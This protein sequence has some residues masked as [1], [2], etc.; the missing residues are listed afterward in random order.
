MNAQARHHFARLLIDRSGG[1]VARLRHLEEVVVG[2]GANQDSGPAQFVVVVPG[3]GQ[4]QVQADRV[5]RHSIHRGQHAGRPF[6]ALIGDGAVVEREVG[7]V[8]RIGLPL[9]PA[10][11]SVQNE[12]DR[13]RAQVGRGSQIDHR[14]I[15]VLHAPLI[16]VDGRVQL[17][18]ALNGAE[19]VFAGHG[20]RRLAVVAAIEV[21]VRIGMRLE[22]RQVDQVSRVENLFG[23]EFGVIVNSLRVTHPL[24]PLRPF[25]AAVIAVDRMLGLVRFGRLLLQEAHVF[26]LAPHLRQR[27][28]HHV[29]LGVVNEDVLRPHVRLVHQLPHHGQHH[30]RGRIDE[31]VALRA[32][33][34]VIH[35]DL[36]GHQFAGPIATLGQLPRTVVVVLE[37]RLPGLLAG[38]GAGEFGQG[39]GQHGVHRRLV[40]V[41]VEP[42]L[43]RILLQM[44]CPPG[45]P[46]VSRPHD[47]AGIDASGNADRSVGPGRDEVEVRDLGLGIRH[48]LADERT[49]RPDRHRQRRDHPQSRRRPV[50]RE[51]A[52][53]PPDQGPDGDG[54]NQ[55]DHESRRHGKSGPLAGIAGA[56][57]FGKHTQQEPDQ[58]GGARA[59]RNRSP[60]GI[61]RA[62]A[63]PHRKPEKCGF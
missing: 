43:V 34:G 58:R 22:Q 25:Q 55:P 14:R 54:A 49:E 4:Q 48:S 24:Y 3:L 32:A 5:E 2:V 16:G 28:G 50:A 8:L 63:G 38:G 33:G 42:P 52:A 60:P 53:K 41:L 36:H 46:R 59:Y 39:G 40:G 13:L 17:R 30:L 21:V 61:G 26:E 44:A 29:A 15:G 23:Y 31:V 37:E 12:Q 9:A 47:A 45:S 56:A 18:R 1:W 20:Q 57:G 10:I 51:Q 35:V 7:E 19:M 6:R 27:V 62:A 11:E